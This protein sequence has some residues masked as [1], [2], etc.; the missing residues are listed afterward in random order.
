MK[1][2]QR[3]TYVSVS[4]V[5]LMEILMSVE[6]GTSCY[7]ENDEYDN[8]GGCDCGYNSLSRIKVMVQEILSAASKKKTAKSGSKRVSKTK[9]SGSG[10]VAVRG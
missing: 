3:L 9:K 2:K 10:R 1:A 5:A 6:S 7:C 4:V 8:T